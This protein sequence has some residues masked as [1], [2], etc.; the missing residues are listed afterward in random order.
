MSVKIIFPKQ[1]NKYPPHPVTLKA[2]EISS[3]RRMYSMEKLL[4][5]LLLFLLGGIKVTPEELEQ[6]IDDLAAQY[7]V[8]T[9]KI[10]A[11]LAARN[12]LALI[13]E[14]LLFDKVQDFLAENAVAL[15]EEPQEEVEQEVEQEAESGEEAHQEAG[16]EE[17]QPPEDA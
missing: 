3:K 1:Q 17:P 9:D 12:Q 5:V 13:E 16:L 7:N 4:A 6:E 10:R 2:T 15:T 8:E 14:G 11:D